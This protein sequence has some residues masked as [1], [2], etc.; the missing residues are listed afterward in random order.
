MNF[1]E[2]F[3]RR[4]VF[5]AMMLLT[6][7]VMGLTSFPRM[8]QELFP[9]ADFPIVVVTGVYPGA[10]SS[11]MESLV[12]KPLEDAIV[13]INGIKQVA[14]YSSNSLSTIIIEFNLEVNN[15]LAS[16]DVRDKLAMVRA[17]LPK[18]MLEPSVLLFDPDTFPIYTCA[19]TG[20]QSKEELTRL[21]NNDILPQL[22]RIQGVGDI[23]LTGD[24]PREYQINLSPER[25]Q[26]HGLTVSGIYAA[27]MTE[28]MDLPG[29]KVR[30]PGRDVTLKLPSAIQSFDDIKNLFITYMGGKSRLDEVADIV[31]GYK[32]VTSAASLNGQDA[33]MLGVLKQSGENTVRVTENV[34]KELERMKSSLPKGVAFVT[35][36][37]DA[38]FVK[39]SNESVFEHLLV[40]GL[41]AVLVLFV[42]LRNWRAT[43]IAGLAIPISLVAT[44]WIMN[45]MG[46]TIN[47][48]TT[49]ALTLVV[50]ILIDDAV[51]DLENI[52]RH[53]EA[54]EDRFSA[55]IN[56]TGEIQLA[57]TA[58]TLSI[59]AVFVPIAF[60]TGYVGKYFRS[61][62][63]TV[64]IAVLFSLLVARTITPMFASLFLKLT[65]RD[66]E[67]LSTHSHDIHE[68][69]QG[70]AIAYRGILEWALKHR[71]TVMF[72]AFA[73]FV[74]GLALV[75][76]I[77]KA[78]MT[79]SDSGET[80]LS[81]EMPRGTTVDL[82]MQEALRIAEGVRKYPEVVNTFITA[83]AGSQLTSSGGPEK[84]SIGVILTDKGKRKSSAEEVQARALK[85]FGGV[86]GVRLTAGS[87][88]GG[89]AGGGGSPVAVQ[90]QGEN[91]DELRMFSEQFTDALKKVPGVI[92][93]QNSL[94]SQLV[95]YEIT[96][97]RAKA[98]E[99]GISSALIA[100]TLRLATTGDVPCTLTQGADKTD[101]RV[102]VDPAYGKDPSK[103]LALT[104]PVAGKG[105]IPIASVASFKVTGGFARIEHLDRQRA[106]SI[107]ANLLPG[108]SIGP[109]T[110]EIEKIK[111][112]MRLPD[113][114]GF[115]LSGQSE[116]M[117]DT[118]TSMMQALGLAIIFIYIILGAQFESFVHPFTIMISLPLSIVGAFLGLLVTGKPLD[119]MSMIGVILL[120]GIVTK[121]AILL[122]DFT[123]TLRD[124]GFDRN[125]AMLRAAPL[126]LRPILMTTAAM[127][128]GML[129]TAL[130]IGSGSEFRAS[131]GIVVI[132]GLITSTFLTLLVVPVVYTLMD[133]LGNWTRSKFGLR[134]GGGRGDHRDVVHA[135]E[136]ALAET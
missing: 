1:S 104:I 45:V 108:Y 80:A 109:I 8:A 29:G 55:A 116:A 68:T 35:A 51:V 5:T 90:M 3:I 76:A 60:M 27:L 125:E 46:L 73:A 25:A 88:G 42:F 58:T 10:A 31:E 82:T 64:T 36:R 39:G 77:P 6:M 50:G 127:I 72:V 66:Q 111:T 62:G 91:L 136:E 87:T 83:G 133:D 75:P 49:M 37:E 103:L 22:K 129:P 85:E 57:V 126:R 130:G 26:L 48:M 61:F 81:L 13:G 30:E 18:D 12:T 132:G 28:N 41:L 20:P 19:I 79:H 84:A 96:L 7:I 100:N 92:D 52:Y 21:V 106:V 135:S 71:K 102:R 44:F 118:F 119:M 93:V 67:R 2:F 24:K 43:I 32:E 98:A 33:I 54:G 117:R 131:M 121:N 123:I 15:R 16:Q 120:M 78:F 17:K 128:L 107:T 11:E 110:Q 86:P 4:P 9:S 34:Q 56:A 69:R 47:M 124:R 94:A 38:K 40:G 74:G 113:R 65:K 112:K 14:S 70:L 122:V 101:L 115:A 59:V 95:E 97:D 134:S 23:Q 89:P 53:M 63:L 114:I 99:L 105:N